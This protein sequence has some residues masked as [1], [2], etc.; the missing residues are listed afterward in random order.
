MKRICLLLIL[1]LN[2]CLMFAAKQVILLNSI[3]SG[4]F[5][6]ASIPE[7]R[8]MQ[9]AHF[10]TCID[11]SGKKL[12]RYSYISGKQEEIILDIEKVKGTSLKKIVGYTFSPNETKI[13]VWSE[14]NPIYR[15]S[16]TTDFQVYDRKRN[17]LEP[18]SDIGFQRDAKFSPDSRSIAFS[19]DNNLFIKR[20][21]FGTEIAVTT[22]GE[23]NSIINGVAD[24]VY[25]EEFVETCAFDWSSDS[26]FLA[27]VKFNEKKVPTYTMP[28]FGAILPGKN[29]YYPGSYSYK[30][31]SAGNLNSTVSIFA[32][33][34][35]TRSA[36]QMILPVAEEDYIPRIRF[37]RYN[38]QLAVMTLNKAQTVFKM[39]YSNPKSAQSTLVLTDQSEKYVEPMYDAIQFSTNNFTYL[40]EKD[41]YRHLY[42]Y[43]DKGGLQKQLTTGKWDVTKFLGCDT[44][45]KIFYYQS[46]EDGPM[47]RSL[48]SIDMKGKKMKISAR[49]GVNKATFNSDYSY[50]VKTWS[51]ITTPQMY[52]VCDE[53]GI[54]VRSVENNKELRSMM[55][56]YQYDDKTFFSLPAA[57]GQKLNGWMLKP[58]AF[59]K[60]KKYP[61]LQIQY[62]GP[63]SQSAL[64]EFDFDW[65]YFLAEKGYIVVCVDGRGTGGRGEA[66][67]KSTWCNLGIQETE[68]QVA[69]AN[70][71]KKQTYIDGSRIGIW[72]WSYGGYI[73]LMSM[74]D[75]STV[76]K[77]GIAVG[78][79]CDWRYYDSVYGER[80][81]RTPQENQ[82]GYDAG[83]PLLRAASLKG[84]LLLVH[85]MMDDNVRV[86]QS[87]D[88]SEALIQSGIQFDMQ[89]YPTSNHSILGET[90]RKHLYNRMADFIFKNL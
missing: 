57:D 80:Y 71:L 64:N 67:R 70:F 26:K 44:I 42:L 83:S 22:D 89:M 46:T 48:Y 86:N 47:E 61:V 41:G 81:M 59:D 31:P 19:R 18:L 11:D 73:T 84:R 90:Y 63:D 52:S 33:S 38:N 27:Y 9:D 56:N 15:H 88:M 1:S 40:S 6:S 58:S 54:E 29:T 24:W 8:S 36:K 10:Y 4:D 79:V 50:F 35:Q 16:F 60:S 13:L 20:L 21:Y 53:E 23:K 76:F 72:G 74:T 3:V 7:M 87:L 66:F 12:I 30:Y 65:E 85:G 55:A 37:T 14:K 39:F 34:L 17:L 2:V 62:S 49:P 43:G 68:D 45:H 77:A 82:S 5:L 51:D 78:A 75:P 32:F 28:L 25:E 69:T